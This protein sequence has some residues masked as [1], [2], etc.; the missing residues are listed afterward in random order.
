M[1]LI[2]TTTHELHDFPYHPMPEYAILSHTWGDDEVI[3]QEMTHSS[4]FSKA[5]YTKI[6]GTCQL[7]IEHGLQ[8][9][10][11]D[12]CCIDKSS[13][14]ELTESINSMF[15]WY[16]NAAV[17]YVYLQDLPVHVGFEEGLPKCR[18][19]TRGWTLQELLAPENIEFFDEG[20]KRRGTKF[21]Y[22]NNI[23]DCSGIPVAVLRGER[24]MARCSVARRM[25]WASKRQTSRIE[26]Q[27][28][29]LLG[30]FDVNMPMIYGEGPKA[31]RRLQ[32]EI[33]KR[34][35]DLIILAWDNLRE[36]KA[37]AMGLFA[38]SSAS[39]A[40]TSDV[41]ASNNSA[42]SFTVTN[43]GLVISG[44]PLLSVAYPAAI[45][46]EC[47][48]ELYCIYLGVCGPRS[49]AVGLILRRIGPG[50]FYRDGSTPM[51]GFRSDLNDQ[52]LNLTDNIDFCIIVD[53]PEEF[54]LP[55][56]FRS[57]SLHV[58]QHRL[59]S[60][61]DQCPDS[62]WDITD[63]AFLNV[64]RYNYCKYPVVMAMIFSASVLDVY[65]D[66]VVLCERNWET[67]LPLCR[68][69]NLA[70][71]RRATKF[72]FQEKHGERHL[73]WD[74]L[75][76]QAPELCGLGNEV[77]VVVHDISHR[78]TAHFE[79]EIVPKISTSRPVFTL[80]LHVSPLESAHA[81]T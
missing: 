69:F 34:N 56:S 7:A 25:A 42:A 39:F 79:E 46:G 30:I 70:D 76:L 50:Y 71:H 26:D 15:Q 8:Y 48:A 55:D 59:F 51:A 60:L 62:L 36:R 35:N 20:W 81:R 38:E 61:R 63:R 13:S 9:A 21:D 80:K 37:R 53:L 58:P 57:L 43:K 28:Y 17:C 74:E 10:W 6:R 68:V 5:G 77:V 27:A 4:R 54:D 29:S 23:A 66:I 16:K 19:L 14:A 72:I 12:T 3:F 18:W 45:Y 33:V 24:D 65:V 11:I 2:N 31:F 44:I 64:D 49:A 40:S 78:V 32:E 52:L 41:D 73:H 1:R 47:N 75:E 67:S 22:V